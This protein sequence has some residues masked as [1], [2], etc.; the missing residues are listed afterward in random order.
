MGW[1]EKPQLSVLCL[2][3]S[4]G[5]EVSVGSH[6][7][8]ELWHEGG[9][10]RSEVRECT[11]GE[12]NFEQSAASPLTMETPEGVDSASHDS[13]TPAGGLISVLLSSISIITVALKLLVIISIS[14]TLYSK[15]R[16]TDVVPPAHYSSSTPPPTSS[17]SPWPSQTHSSVLLMPFEIIYVE[18]SWF[19]GTWCA[20]VL[21]PRLHDPLGLVVNVL[22]PPSSGAGVGSSCRRPEPHSSGFSTEQVPG[23]G[24]VRR[25]GG[26]Q[27]LGVGLQPGRVA[28]TVSGF[29]FGIYRGSSVSRGELEPPHSHTAITR[30]H[31]PRYERPLPGVADT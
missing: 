24:C 12:E 4:F 20:A 16:F 31:E 6:V 2:M 9:T 18:S 13:T 10:R 30:G 25:A 19:L 22:L 11:T 8:M 7:S 1:T 17:S 23:P 28:R 3:E 27:G 14:H 26:A 21:R 15:P 5:E 29:I